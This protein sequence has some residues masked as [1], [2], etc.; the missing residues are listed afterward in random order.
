MRE[1]PAA[2][3]TMTSGI[4]ASASAISVKRCRGLG[5]VVLLLPVL[6]RLVEQGTQVHLVTRTEWADTLQELRGNI[7]I[8]DQC[9]AH[10]IDLDAA[11]E[12]LKPTKHRSAEFADILGVADTIDAAH[13]NVPEEW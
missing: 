3:E 1:V 7:S 8:D 2:L 10:T 11:T 5:N 13:I 12:S 6:D 9:R 4:Q